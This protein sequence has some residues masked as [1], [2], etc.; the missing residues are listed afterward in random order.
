M[1]RIIAIVAVTLT[2]GACATL[3]DG[4]QVFLPT[5]SIANPATPQSL[6]DI[7]ATYG[8]AQVAALTYIDRYRAGN[9]CTRTR[10][11]SLNN[12]CSRRSVVER[13]QRADDVAISALDKATAFVTNNPTLD[14]SDAIAAAR[15]AV[16]IF[17]NIAKGG[18]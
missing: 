1:R 6:Y 10:P 9:R 5:A 13:L 17:Y 12:L 8:I 7:K 3:P 11:E 4:R 2:L 15:A 16:T 14:A 18:A